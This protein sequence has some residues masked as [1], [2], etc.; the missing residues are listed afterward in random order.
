MMPLSRIVHIVDDDIA[1][2]QSLDMLLKSAGL[3]TRTHRSARDFLNEVQ[4]QSGCVVT[5]I[6]MP[7][8]TGIE[9][10]EEMENRKISIPA[11]M[12]TG[13][14]SVSLCVQSM[15]MGAIDFIQKPFDGDL[16]IN[17]V[18]AALARRGDK[19]ETSCRIETLTKREKDVLDGIVKGHLNKTIAH[20]LGISI[21]T[22]ET[23][24]ANVM[25][26]TKAQSVSDLVR[27]TLM[28]AE[29]PTKSDPE[30][31]YDPESDPEGEHISFSPR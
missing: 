12:I 20:N 15:K 7:E 28:V 11:I 30:P 14:G 25:A 26:K 2:L 16:M 18:R 24:R 5:D 17:S 23:Y 1:V 29:A 19:Y 31:E 10:L 4:I 13:H 27:M 3:N 8:V 22:V 9:L 21:R 6:K